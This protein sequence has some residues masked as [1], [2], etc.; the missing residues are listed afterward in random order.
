VSDKHA[1]FFVALPTATS[2]QIRALIFQ[3]R[4]LVAE[5]TGIVLE[6]EIQMVGFDDDN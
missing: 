1:N 4:D 2:G 3:V 6:P 5:R